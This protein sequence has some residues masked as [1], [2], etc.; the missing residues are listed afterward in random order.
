LDQDVRKVINTE[1]FQLS[2]SKRNLLRPTGPRDTDVMTSGVSL[3]LM[4]Q[5]IEKK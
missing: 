3:V 4:C 5:K 2:L 1:L